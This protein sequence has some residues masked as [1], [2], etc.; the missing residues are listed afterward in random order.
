MLLIRYD[1][2]GGESCALVDHDY[3]SAKKKESRLLSPIGAGGVG[4]IV[5]NVTYL[6]RNWNI[7]RFV[8]FG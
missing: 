5:A 4:S 3:S 2:D 8:V 7:C 6:F 1:V